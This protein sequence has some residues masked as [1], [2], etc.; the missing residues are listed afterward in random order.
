MLLACCLAIT[1]MINVRREKLEDIQAIREVNEQAFGQPQEANIVDKIRNNC[2]DI[3][4]MVAI[5]QNRIVGHILFSP[6]IIESENGRVEGMGLAP[7]AVVP[8][9]QRQRIGSALIRDG[10]DI[11]R[12]RSCPFI[13]VLGHPD[14]YPRFG[15][16]S[17]FD[18]G[19]KS[20]WE[21]VPD[22]AFMV[23]FFNDTLKHNVSG[24]AKYRD[25]FDDAM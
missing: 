10:I 13:I 12:K 24:L 23:M 8:K 3:L 17:A 22:N 9:Y 18:Y 25:E 20:Q 1:K 16:V 2:E 7:M 14:Y 19:L 4:S 21:G 11:L 6:S 5:V 15:F